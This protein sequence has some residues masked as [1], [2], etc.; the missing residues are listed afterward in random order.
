M[1]ININNDVKNFNGTTGIQTGLDAS[2]PTAGVKGRY[3]F[4]IDTDIIYYDNGTTWENFITSA[5]GSGFVTIGT[6]QT[7]TALKNFTSGVTLNTAPALKIGDGTTINTLQPQIQLYNFVQDKNIK[8]L[9]DASGNLYLQNQSSVQI[10]TISN[11][12]SIT[13]TSGEKLYGQVG[14]ALIYFDG[15][16]NSLYNANELINTGS[17]GIGATPPAGFSLYVAKQMTGGVQAYGLHGSG[18]ILSDVTSQASYFESSS[19]TQATTFTLSN[20]RHFHATQNSVGAGSTITTQSG[21]QAGSSLTG[22]TNNYGFRGSI[23]SG[24]GRFNIYM[25]GTALNYFNGTTLIGSATD[26]ASGA[27]LQVTGNI[28]FQN[29]FNRKTASYTLVLSDQND[30]IEMNVA[31]ANNLTV[32]LNSTVAFPTGT[33][34]AITQY[35]A[36][37]TTI[38]ATGGVTIRSAGGLLSISAQY[39]MATL[40]KVAT[41]EWY[42]IG[43]LIA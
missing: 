36:G 6:I 33:E 13:L 3:Y 1:S 30:I 26:N 5:T 34:I 37:K 12:G 9:I 11:S 8:F 27:K 25:D 16:F 10:L 38:V 41:N 14:T 21:F 4:A 28:S 23:A 39:A 32:P 22:A 24:T 7:I 20:L 29:V 17:I 18:T 42:L 40:V 15:Y 2:I 43:S 35:G 19:N 31:T